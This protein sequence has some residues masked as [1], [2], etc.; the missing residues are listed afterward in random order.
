MYYKDLTGQAFGNLTVL[1]YM[2]THEQRGAAWLCRCTCGAEVIKSNNVLKAGLKSCSAKCGVAASNKKRA[3]HG[4]AVR[5]EL[6][7]EYAAW[8]SMKQ[9]CHNPLNKKYPFY[10]GRGITVS[11]EWDTFAPFF[12]HI[13]A[14]PTKAHTIDRID[15]SRGYEPGN[16]R[17]ATRKEQSNNIR[18]NVRIVHQGRD[19][20]LAEWAEALDIPLP[21]L[22]KR[23][24]KE[25]PVASVLRPRTSRVRNTLY[26]YA[27][28]KRTIT[29]WAKHLALP[30]HVVHERI[31][32]G[33]AIR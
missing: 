25:G 2:G 3:T 28:E 4:Q 15:N 19:L 20:T 23:A 17:W 32:T 10:G 14:A 26:E 24:R 8:I 18:S 22:Y 29:E 13:G 7:K 30:Y 21:M 31:T 33:K 9:R 27:G 1:R 12:A 6:T 5:G 16:V 11:P